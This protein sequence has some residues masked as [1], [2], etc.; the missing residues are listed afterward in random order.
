MK[1]VIAALAAANFVVGLSVLIV[2]GMLTTLASAFS[3]SI[4]IAGQLI[5]VGSIVMGIGAPLIAGFTSHIDRRKL[6]VFSLLV[7]AIGHLLCALAA[8]FTFLIVLRALTLISAAIITPQAAAT[9]G[10]MAPAHQRGPAVAAI[11]IGWSLA[12]VIA[13][14]MSNWL[15]TQFDWRAPFLISSLVSCIVA[16]WVWIALPSGLTVPR[17]SLDSWRQV[18]RHPV[19]IPV[20]AV[21]LVSFVGQFMIFSYQVPILERGLGISVLWVATLLLLYGGFGLIGS[22]LSVKLIA[23]LGVDRFVSICLCL[24]FVAAFFWLVAFYV[25]SNWTITVIFVAQV[26]WGLSGFA[27]NSAQQGR[28]MVV[29][30]ELASASIALNTSFLYIGQ[31]LGTAAGAQ[32]ISAS[33]YGQL[34]VGTMLVLILTICLSLFATYRSSAYQRSR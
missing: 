30:P 9:I 16:I 1:P 8:N 28:L 6:L 25:P 21:T 5:T 24:S 11:F 7:F 32:I 13:L 20:L 15:A 31:A 23:R 18:I 33:G 17:L 22:S 14:P 26:L 27:T 29:A 4:P 2:P 34:P 10:V 12:S 3:V 19:L